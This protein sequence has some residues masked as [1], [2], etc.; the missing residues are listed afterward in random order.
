MDILEG[1]FYVGEEIGRAIA[2]IQKEGDR[3]VNDQP[4]I[5]DFYRQNPISTYLSLAQQFIPGTAENHPNMAQAIVGY[6][7]KELIPAP[8]LAEF[9]RAKREN[10]LEAM[11]GSLDSEAFVE[12][13]K[14]ASKRRH[15]LHGT[16]ADAMTR[17][18]GL[19]PWSSEERAYTVGVFNK[20]KKDYEFAAKKVSEVFGNNRTAKNVYDMLRYEA[21][22]TKNK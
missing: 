20:D 9:T 11:F 2:V 4:G 21:K 8:E 13:C 19:T 22:R 15:E 7:L 17:G 1:T 6:A 3:L 10:Q 14:R 16:N 5:A 12:H 18:R